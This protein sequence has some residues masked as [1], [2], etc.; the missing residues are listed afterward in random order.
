MP[1]VSQAELS[2]VRCRA[3]KIRC[4]R[5]KEECSNCQ[6][7][8]V[9]CEYTTPGK[10]VNHVKLLCNSVAKIEERLGDIEE[11][12][13][14]LAARLIQDDHEKV[15]PAESAIPS[16]SQP[17]Q[18][19][20]SEESGGSVSGPVQHCIFRNHESQIDRYYGPGALATLCRE[21]QAAV[22]TSSAST[23]SS[24]PSDTVEQ[25]LGRLILGA[26]DQGAAS[27]GRC[28]GEM[29][30]R[31]PAKRLFL[32]IQSQFF[33]R[34]QWAMDVFAAGLFRAR[35]EQLYTR[36]LTI[37][38]TPWV[39]SLHLITL[40]VLGLEQEEP[41]HQLDTQ[42]HISD[43][44]AWGVSWS[45]RSS[46]MAPRLIDVQTLA[47]LSRYGQQ[48][49]PLPV[50]E[51]IHT[52]ACIRAKAI[53]LHCV[54]P[55]GGRDAF[56]PEE[57][58]ERLHLYHHLR[59]QDIRFAILRGSTPWLLGH[60]WPALKSSVGLGPIQ[61]QLHHATS[62][63]V[64]TTK[65]QQVLAD[66]LGQLDQWAQEHQIFASGPPNGR[67]PS[68]R[69]LRLDFLATRIAILVYLNIPD[70]LQKALFDARIACAMLLRSF[71][72]GAP[73][74]CEQLA[75]PSSHPILNLGEEVS[76]QLLY[77][78]LQDDEEDY[79]SSLVRQD[80]LEMFSIRA[81][82]VIA[83]ALTEPT[84]AS[85]QTDV[86]LLRGVSSL[87]Y[88]VGRR[89]PVGN[90]LLK[91]GRVFDSV[92]GIIHE[93]RRQDPPNQGDIHGDPH[94]DPAMGV[95]VSPSSDVIEGLPNG[96]EFQSSDPAY[97]TTFPP[98]SFYPNASSTMPLWLLGSMVADETPF[99]ETAM[100]HDQADHQ[101]RPEQRPTAPVSPSH[102]LGPEL[103][104]LSLPKPLHFGL[105]ADAGY[106]M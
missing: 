5:E 90:Y 95:T 17:P 80:A 89:M 63:N 7:D 2:C 85:L 16:G 6:R 98:S 31:L 86:D 97:L 22:S 73:V 78:D 39:L 81:F 14:A 61:E 62:P 45:E 23:A 37:D 91:L 4:G 10:R 100:L 30:L 46:L 96:M 69:S 54:G 41:G 64:P 51:S 66:L 70:S 34:C 20:T 52:Q 56:S 19:D 55:E 53:G 102:D 47:L 84:S 18:S 21:F 106:G 82:F 25:H 59:S 101:P 43:I 67:N 94:E 9:K 29:P 32:L 8:G 76:Y 103:P 99:L 40:L 58:E 13:S 68:V 11:R 49:L 44:F 77:S 104:A 105:S 27:L 72:A 15:Y 28:T 1:S 74:T 26:G 48:F 57:A 93:L 35:V 36:P 12:L 71:F 65:R 92:L 38:D 50:A 83:A 79:F 24:S 88:S 60:D 3:R 87:Y 75:A 33:Q 42:I